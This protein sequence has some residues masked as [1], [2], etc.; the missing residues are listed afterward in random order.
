MSKLTQ[1][2]S[3]IDNS[4]L[5]IHGYCNQIEHIMVIPIALMH[6]ILKYFV[7]LFIHN[8]SSALKSVELFTFKSNKI[9]AS[10][11]Y[12]F[13]EFTFKHKIAI[14]VGCVYNILPTDKIIYNSSFCGVLFSKSG[15]SCYSGGHYQHKYE[16]IEISKKAIIKLKQTMYNNKFNK[17]II[18]MNN[19]HLFTFSGKNCSNHLMHYIFVCFFNRND[20]V[21]ICGKNDAPVIKYYQNK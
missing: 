12:S 7:G 2:I 1:E 11:S 4:T 10:S 17:F 15:I 16:G 9:T 19:H 5:L 18:Y 6:L 8:N 14:G 3:N 21:F 20:S 13:T